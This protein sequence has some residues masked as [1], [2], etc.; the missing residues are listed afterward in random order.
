MAEPVIEL[1]TTPTLADILA[2]IFAEMSACRASRRGSSR[3]S[4][5][6]DTPIGPRLHPYVPLRRH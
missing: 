3:D 2:R 4:D 5:S 1:A 6:H